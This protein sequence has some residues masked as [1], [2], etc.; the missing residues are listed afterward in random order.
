M[1]YQPLVKKIL[2]TKQLTPVEFRLL[3]LLMT[4]MNK[5]GACYPSTPLLAFTLDVTPRAIQLQ[6]KS[7]VKKDFII[8]T[9]RH[10]HSSTTE[11][12]TRLKL[13]LKE[14]GREL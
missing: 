7:L 5:S 3:I 12:S 11:L 2:L 6:L 8:I 10:R 9:P 14:E 1:F 13:W 4:F